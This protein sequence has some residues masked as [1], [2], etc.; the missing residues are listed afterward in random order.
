MI[1]E[2]ILLYG[3]IVAIMNPFTALNNYLTLTETME[4]EEALTVLKHAMLVVLF[5][6]LTFTVAGRLILEFYHLSLASLRLGG[7]ILLLYISIDMLSGQ[8][9]TRSVEGKEVAVVPLATPMIVGPGTMTL[10]I[11]LGTTSPIIHVIGAFLLSLATIAFSLRASHLFKR[12]LGR[13]GI[14][15]MARFM[16]L[17]IASVAAE[18]IHGAII[19]WLNQ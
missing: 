15:A 11:H 6:G 1:T 12:V 17:I 14:K 9:K 3:Q 18:M 5:L 13:N 8:P 4:K 2:I 16:A 10:L 19:E 7:G